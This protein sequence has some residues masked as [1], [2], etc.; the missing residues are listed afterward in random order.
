MN[1]S[2]FFIKLIF[3]FA[4]ILYFSLEYFDV[5]KLFEGHLYII[6]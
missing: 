2:K 3:D 5:F 6:E 4:R 1:I